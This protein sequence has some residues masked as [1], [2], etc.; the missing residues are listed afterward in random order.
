VS[1]TRPE[2]QGKMPQTKLFA[3]KAEKNKNRKEIL[4]RKRSGRQKGR[5]G[6]AKE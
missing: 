1:G 4:Q 5:A 2:G 6:V 3:Q